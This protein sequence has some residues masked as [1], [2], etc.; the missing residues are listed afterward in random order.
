M[1]FMFTGDNARSNRL[2]LQL[3]LDIRRKLSYIQKVKCWHKLSREVGEFLSLEIYTVGKP[4]S[5]K[6]SIK[7]L[8]W[9]VEGTGPL[10]R[11]PPALFSRML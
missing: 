5:G 11:I 1:L 3:K 6:V 8:L 2:K 10:S 9:A 4:L 7:M